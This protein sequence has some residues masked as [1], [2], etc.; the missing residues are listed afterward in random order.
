LEKRTK[1]LF[2]IGSVVLAL[3]GCA[4]QPDVHAPAFAND[5]FAPFSRSAAVAIAQGEWRYWGSPVID[6]PPAAY[7]PVDAQAMRERDPGDWQQVGLYWWLGMNA[8]HNY[9]RW[10][11]KHNATG[12]TFQPAINGRFAWSAAFISYIMRIAGAGPHFPYAP[13]HAHYID[14]AW[15][16]AH[17]KIANPLLV[18]EN[19]ATYAPIPGDLICA[20]RGRAGSMTYADLPSYGFFPAHCAIVVEQTP[21][22]LSVIGGNVDDTVALTHVPTTARNT[23]QHRDGTI[24]DQRYDWFVVLKVLYRQ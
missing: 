23:L 3:S 17:G 19:P 22:M 16:A 24:V 7:H 12:K 15:N 6:A 8:G 11:G 1:K 4:V 9:D 10:T 18:A 14:Y 5:A 13:D 21:S 2:G 20:G